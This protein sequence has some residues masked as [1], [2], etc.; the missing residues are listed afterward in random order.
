MSEKIPLT[1]KR[2]IRDE[3]YK[4]LGNATIHGGAQIVDTNIKLQRLF[5]ICLMLCAIAMIIWHLKITIDIFINQPPYTYTIDVDGQS[6]SFPDVTVCNSFPTTYDLFTM[7][8]QTEE[9]IFGLSKQDVII[10]GALQT[11]YS[12]DTILRMHATYDMKSRGY[13]DFREIVIDCRYG[14][15][16]CRDA[17][18][19]KYLDY[20]IFGNCYTFQP[21]DRTNDN[22]I[23]LQLLLYNGFSTIQQKRHEEQDTDTK[24]SNNAD[25]FNGE[26]L[27]QYQNYDAR[28]MSRERFLTMYGKVAN[29]PGNV[30]SIHE[31]D[32]YPYMEYGTFLQPGTFTTIHLKQTA[33]NMMTNCSMENHMDYMRQ[34]R[35]VSTNY[36]LRAYKRTR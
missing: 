34:S 12:I 27:S 16:N 18:Y 31:K 9:N 4:F 1:L 2:P 32:S 24:N 19:W 17:K 22:F 11:N 14:K 20:Y 23:R 29:S 15:I 5:W 36:D 3:T 28:L 25:I 13:Y 10:N 8:A 33:Y 6:F 21:F 35:D 7:S 26:Q 30:I